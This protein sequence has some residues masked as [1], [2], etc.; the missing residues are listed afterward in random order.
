MVPQFFQT[1]VKLDSAMMA[2]TMGWNSGIAGTVWLRDIRDID[3]KTEQ[4]VE[5]AMLINAY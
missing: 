1:V 4:G 5:K 3:P 2:E